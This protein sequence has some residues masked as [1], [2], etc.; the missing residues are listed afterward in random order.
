MDGDLDLGMHEFC[1]PL[2]PF[3]FVS[4]GPRKVLLFVWFALPFACAHLGPLLVEQAKGGRAWNGVPPWFCFM[5]AVLEDV[6]LIDF[7]VFF[8]PSS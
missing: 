8:P 7:R 2:A 4:G 1:L 6:S 3:D 5:V